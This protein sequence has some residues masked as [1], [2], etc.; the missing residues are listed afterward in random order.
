M[1]PSDQNIRHCLNQSFTERLRS[2]NSSV[3]TV[4]RLRV[5]RMQH[6]TIALKP[7]VYPASYPKGNGGPFPGT[8]QQDIE[9]TTLLY[10]VVA[11]RMYWYSVSIPPC[12]S[13]TQS[14]I[15]H[16]KHVSFRLHISVLQ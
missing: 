4:T 13:V 8:K 2:W 7:A 14:F 9:L 12:V 5:R 6:Q 1:S 15:K 16:S 3:S 10:L 11:L